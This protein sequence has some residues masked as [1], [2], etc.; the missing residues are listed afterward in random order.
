MLGR[1][2][3]IAD[4][5][6]QRRVFRLRVVVLAV[7]VVA[8][9]GVAVYRLGEL[10]I[11]DHR[12]YAQAAR[13]NRVRVVPVAPPRG[14]IYSRDGK[15]LA[16]NMPSYA[17]EIIPADVPDLAKTVRQLTRL[18]GISP[19]EVHRFE[20][21]RR[22]SPSYRAVPLLSQ[23]DPH[24]VARFAVESFRFPGVHIQAHLVRYYPY[25]RLTTDSVGYVGRINAPELKKV[26]ATNYAGTDYFG[27]GGLELAFQQ[28][29][30]GKV[31]YKVVKVDAVGRP[32]KTVQSQLP[33]PGRDM[34]L[35]LDMGLQR[36]AQKAMKGKAGVVVAMN[37]R[38]GAVLALV[39]NPSFNPNWFVNGIS[40][41]R[42]R[43][44]LDNPHKP[45]WNRA[46]EASYAPGSTIKPFIALGALQAHVITPQQ[47]IY[48][49]PYYM[50]PGTHHKF[51]DWDPYG[52]G[53]TDLKKAIARSVDTYFYPV[54]YKMG[55][56]AIDRTLAKFGF[57]Q[58]PMPGLPGESAGLLPTPKWKKHNLGRPWYPG[59][60][61][62][63]GIGQGYLQVTPL[64]LA[65]A[66]SIIAMRGHGYQPHLLRA[67]RDSPNG[68]LHLVKPQ[69]LPV[70]HFRR[71][72]WRDVIA[73]M[74][75]EA[76]SP[77]GT[78]YWPF[79]GFPLPVAGKTGTAQVFTSPGN[80]FTKH[81]KIPYRLR[82][83]AL[84]EGFT[85]I[86]KPQLVVVVVV[87]HSKTM[88]GPAASVARKVMEYWRTHQSQI[89]QPLSQIKF[90]P[91]KPH[92][93]SQSSGQKLVAHDRATD[94][95]KLAL[96]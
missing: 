96:S 45:L 86:K 92:K 12:N 50:I 68:R 83:N 91:M 95:A 28:Y 54:A 85:P 71:S 23:L 66:V 13:A 3:P 21:L 90:S 44:L 73:G 34:V 32:L 93:S 10:Q 81:G 48:A 61:V 53:W 52:Q 47:K 40:E 63:M 6:Q 18:L 59:D 80:P 20:Q 5:G 46:V 11:Q 55:I 56:Q 70:V 76:E 72:Y 58:M 49:G 8:M 75:A 51:W 37:P 26:N 41:K 57:G 24:Q 64:Q 84:F 60:T 25:G 2:S 22:A 29:L 42:Y 1:R 74:R 89:S 69:A 88:L 9:L 79:R 65:K 35:T 87:E 16:Q 7:V 82:N 77:H 15:L 67:W 39:S 78:S 31:G 4:A 36:V 94:R 30:H 33:V 27:K 43:K 62:V 17:L 19:R 38:N 14:L